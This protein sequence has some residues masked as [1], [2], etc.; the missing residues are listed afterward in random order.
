MKKP[1]YKLYNAENEYICKITLEEIIFLWGLDKGTTLTQAID[2]IKTVD[3]YTL[4]GV[5]NA[6][7]MEV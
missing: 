5:K 3:N 1:R 4:K 7:L 6:E 2:T